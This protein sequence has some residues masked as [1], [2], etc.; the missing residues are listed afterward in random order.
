MMVYGMSMDAKSEHQRG[1]EKKNENQRVANV[2][3][4]IYI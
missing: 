3:H 1:R 2:L 4:S